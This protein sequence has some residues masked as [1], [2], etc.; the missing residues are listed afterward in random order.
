MERLQLL[1][2]TPLTEKLHALTGLVRPP[3]LALL[4]VVHLLVRVRLKIIGTLET[5]HDSD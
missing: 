3:P 2:I 4:S 5:M 1:A